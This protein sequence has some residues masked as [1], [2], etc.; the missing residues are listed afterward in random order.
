MSKSSWAKVVILGQEYL[1]QTGTAPSRRHIQGSKI[2]KRLPSVKYSFTVLENRIFLKKNFSKKLHSQK[3]GPSGA[4]GLAS[5]S[6]WRAKVS[7]C[8]KTERVD[9]LRF[10][11]IHSVAKHEKIEGNKNFHFR[12][13]ISQCRKKLKGGTLWVISTSILSQNIKNNAGGPFGEKFFYSKKVSQ[14][15]KN[16]RRE[17]LVSPG[18]VCYAE[19]Q[20]K[21]FWFSSLDQIVHFDAIIFCRTFV[22]L[23]W[24]VHVNEKKGSL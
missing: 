18:M 2:A 7:Q 11:N 21:P 6:P 9:P 16:E 10:F 12:E 19:K 15:R 13:K 17:S 20:E 1:E 22:E 4:P 24:S 8:R 3:N 5:A 23:F 14:C